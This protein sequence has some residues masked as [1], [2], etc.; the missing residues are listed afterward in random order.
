[1][2]TM[3]AWPITGVGRRLP[4]PL[5][6]QRSA[7]VPGKK[8][9]TESETK[10][11][12][13][14]DH[15][16]DPGQLTRL[17]ISASQRNAEHMSKSAKHHQ[18]GRPGMNGANQPTKLHAVGDVL[19]ALI[20]FTGARMVVQQEQNAG[21]Q[22]NAEQE[23]SQSAEKIPGTVTVNGNRFFSQ[24]RK[25]FLQVEALVDPGLN[26]GRG[27]HDQAACFRIT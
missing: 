19:D 24:R 8:I 14:Q 22:L 16:A 5:W 10:N 6:W 18:V 17:A 23:Q 21:K 11:E 15:A 25:S 3:M 4:F 26:S 1:M 13:Q 20:G 7:R 12:E 2:K 9:A 27:I